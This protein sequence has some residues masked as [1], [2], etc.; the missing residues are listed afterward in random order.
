M[1]YLQICMISGN[2]I[3]KV[4]VNIGEWIWMRFGTEGRIVQIMY[5]T[6]RPGRYIVKGEEKERRP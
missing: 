5:K 4:S 6:C 3:D 1:V 2:I